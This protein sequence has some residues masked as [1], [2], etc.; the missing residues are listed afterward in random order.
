MVGKKGS[1]G[2]RQRTDDPTPE[3]RAL[4]DRTAAIKSAA[5]STAKF[6]TPTGGGVSLIDPPIVV[7]GGGSIDVDIPEKF[8]EKGSG[9]KGGKYKGDTQSLV[10]VVI[11]GGA[12]I[13]VN[14]TSKIEINYK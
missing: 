14:A 12:P 4:T 11:D 6:D 7:Q 9:K 13:H 10:S 8:K 3:R 1:P 5:T 2:K